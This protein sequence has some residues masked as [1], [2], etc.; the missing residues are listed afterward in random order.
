M[1]EK[2]ALAVII[3]VAVA[4]A[5]FIARTRVSIRRQSSDLNKAWSDIEVLL[6]RRNNDLP[7]LLQTCRS[8]MPEPQEA[9]RLVSESRAEYLKAK[10]IP[11]KASG[12]ASL[13]RALRTLFAEAGRYP[14]VKAN[15]TFSQLQNDLLEI[16]ERIEDR[17]E[18][19]NDDVRRFNSRLARPPAA[20][21]AAK[22][23]V[24]PQP[25][26]EASKKPST[27]S[28]ASSKSK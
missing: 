14:E 6:K 25:L 8:Y 15:S 27:S 20:W 7:R 10:S 17:R 16:E 9:L 5:I 2:V 18:L 12:H 28:A 1:E 4:V 13:H 26:F 21:L 22:M 11:E 3:I 24:K 23:N 19:F